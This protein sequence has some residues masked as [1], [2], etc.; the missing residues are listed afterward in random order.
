MTK[1]FDV[2]VICVHCGG[3]VEYRRMAQKRQKLDGFHSDPF[4]CIAYLA[5]RIRDIGQDIRDRDGY[6]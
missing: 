1:K 2:P 3:H 4:T 5:N 6:F